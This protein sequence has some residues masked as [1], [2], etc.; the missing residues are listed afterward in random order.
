MPDY[1]HLF[2]LDQSTPFGLPRFTEISDD[3]YLLA[4]RQ[5]MAERLVSLD[6]MAADD[7]PPTLQLLHDWEA[8]NRLF[9]RAVCAFWTL[10]DADTNPR[11][12]AIDEEISPELAA[13]EDTIYLNPALYARFL[14]LEARSQAGDVD[15]DEEDAWLL[16][17]TLREFRRRGVALGESE[18]T[19]L[20][21]IN[22][23]LA[24]LAARFAALVIEGRAQAALSVATLEE[25]D[26]LGEEQIAA[27]R[28]A[29]EARQQTGYVLELVNTTSQPMLASL[30]NRQTRQALFE[31][32]V[33]RGQSGE[34]DVRPLILE[35]LRLRA[36]KAAI[37]GFE[38]Y[39]AYVADGGCAKTTTNVMSLLTKVAQAAQVNVSKEAE[40][41]QALLT[42][43]LPGQKL[44]PWDWQYYAERAK[45]SQL[46]LDDSTI[47]P[48][49]SFETVL[50]KGV[51]AA[52]TALYGISFHLRDDIDGY[53]DD[54][55]AYEV[56]DADGS[57]LAL[58][59]FDPYARSSKQGGAWMTS[60]VTQSRLFGELP[61]VT[62][63]C[64]QPKPQTG[65]PSLMT[66]DEV[67]TLF[68]EFGHDLHGLLSDVRYPSRSGTETPSDFVEFPSQVNE[69]WAWEPSLI[70]QYARHW[71]TGEP[72]PA[73]MI[74]TLAASR[75]VGEGYAAA[76]SYQAM[77]LD[78]V[79]HQTPVADL[80][81]DIN[82]INAFE[83]RAL[84]KSGV[85]F[86]PVPPR[87]RSCYFSHIWSI[88]YS[89]AYYSYLWSEIMDADTVAWFAENGGLGRQT[90]DRF[91]KYVLSRGW[92][93][94]V[95]E[96]Y[97][98]FRGADPDPKYLLERH[99]LV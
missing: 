94:D 73:E 17:E 31:V 49:L 43:D 12:D 71:Q 76:E 45:A 28:A 22:E 9:E 38:H 29:A 56:L 19:R 72:M 97:R 18:A 86:E 2:G 68:H 74:E 4:M 61:V 77:L 30:A 13:H 69:I 39:A 65:R 20:R 34:T 35:L 53:T 67:I 83:Y 90:G 7:T 8:A 75:H 60:L 50:E 10:K 32:S 16:A 80:P 64:N 25:L 1:Y 82:Q 88:D 11:I 81:T 6:K 37:L 54:C 55:R 33:G 85:Y 48:Y 87:Y 27:A 24:T 66:W 36:E 41:L 47:M 23:R 59:L 89:A 5:G 52:A 95:M 62:N 57:S 15:L 79:W 26:G 42:A 70:A 96:A 91:R 3:D 58:V 84:V 46:A 92:S 21:Q 98:Q 93:M 63:N 44:Q 40:P 78:Q 51:F 14:A 99:N